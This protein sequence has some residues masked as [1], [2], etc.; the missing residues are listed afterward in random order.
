MAN[1]S[2]LKDSRFLDVR[3]DDN[4]SE[5]ENF[6]YS[7]VENSIRTEN[8]CIN[9]GSEDLKQQVIRALIEGAEGM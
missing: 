7:A 4:S 9:K 8:L 6:V 5:I 1:H 2:D 3:T